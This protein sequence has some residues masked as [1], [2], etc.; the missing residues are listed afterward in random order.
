MKR[1]LLIEP[2]GGY[3]RLDRCMQSINSWGGAYRFPLNLARIAAHLSRIGCNVDF[4]DLQADKTANLSEKVS[5]FNPDLCILSCGF[6]SMKIDSETA[7]QISDISKEIHISTFGVAPTLLKESFFAFSTWGFDIHFDSIVVGGEP[8]LGYEELVSCIEIK[9]NAVIESSMKKV[10]AIDTQLARPL[11][12]HS[13]YKSPFT[14]QNATYIEGTYGCPFRCNFC[15]VPVLY[16]G[17][18]S[19]RKPGD[20]INEFQYVIENNNVSQITLWDE[21]TTFQKSFIKELC[22]GLIELRKSR[23]K[24]FQNFVWTTRSTTALLD[25]EIVEKMSRSG[26]SGI[27]LGIESFSDAVLEKVEKIISVDSNYEAIRLLKKYDIISIGHFI[28]GHLQDSKQTIEYTIES[29][30]NSEL[31]FAQFYCAVP[32]PGTKLF[33]MASSLN[34]IR[35]TDLTM[36]ELSNPIMDTMNGVSHIE[37][38]KYRKSALETFWTSARWQKIDELLSKRELPNNIH[39]DKLKKWNSIIPRKSQRNTIIN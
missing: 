39:K 5:Q 21:G 8:A 15:V 20:I 28:L 1:V 22:D 24:R 17:R 9:D 26:L 13:L 29:A 23:D 3:I 19:K 25:E 7:R 34:L 2:T 12:N 14:G 31:N 33:D 11:F 4:I 30:V 27:T 38:G 6:P 37:I 18:F 10:K 35:E 16:E 32:Y 36:Y